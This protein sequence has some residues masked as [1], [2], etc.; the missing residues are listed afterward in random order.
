MHAIKEIIFQP[1]IK[2]EYISDH[3]GR[4]CEILKI[5]GQIWHLTPTAC[6]P[7]SPNFA[8]IGECQVDKT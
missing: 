5:L 3:V 4:N 8:C 6:A 1:A 7:K 2:D